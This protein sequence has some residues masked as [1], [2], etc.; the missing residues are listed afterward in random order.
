MSEQGKPRIESPRRRTEHGIICRECSGQNVR[1]LTTRSRLYQ[2]QDGSRV[3]LKKQ[4]CCCRACG[5]IWW[6]HVRE[7]EQ[8]IG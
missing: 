7:T 4:E 6:R 8:E 1:I 3:K 5:R 2:R